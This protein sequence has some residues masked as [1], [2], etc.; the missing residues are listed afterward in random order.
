MCGRIVVAA[1]RELLISP[2][3]RESNHLENL[4]TITYGG[5]PTP[6]QRRHAVPRTSL[7]SSGDRPRGQ[8]PYL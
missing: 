8:A 5:K 2:S 7:Y 4:L 1:N 6:V 3:A